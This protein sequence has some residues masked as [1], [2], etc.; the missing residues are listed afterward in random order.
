M[1]LEILV[2]MIA[3]GKSTY[4]RQRADDGA[5]VICHD[6]LTA[7]VHASYRY[8]QEKRDLYREMEEAIVRVALEA[9][10]DVV[11]DRTHL[12]RESRWRWISFA[13]EEQV[14][15]E[16][17]VFAVESAAVHA[18]RRC[19]SDPRG[20]AFEEWLRV[21]EHHASQAAEEPFYDHEGFDEIVHK[22]PALN[23]ASV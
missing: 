16:A 3:S 4:A 2:G 8:E 10:L 11:I 6:D 19:Y 15:I 13:R 23:A 12:T 5:I 1:K 9:E 14:R 20:R 18:R 22:I 21:A 17:V 7:M